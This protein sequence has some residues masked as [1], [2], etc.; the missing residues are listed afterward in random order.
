MKSSTLF[1]AMKWDLR[2][3]VTDGTESSC[4]LLMRLKKIGRVDRIPWRMSSLM[5]RIC[6]TLMKTGTATE[7]PR[8]R[9]NVTPKSIM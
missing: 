9:K 1:Q 3:L 7:F 4:L 8:F 5:K 6:Y 2:S